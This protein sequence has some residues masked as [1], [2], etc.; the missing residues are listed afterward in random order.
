MNSLQVGK[1][2]E[3]FRLETSKMWKLQWGRR[4]LSGGSYLGKL[5]VVVAKLFGGQVWR[6]RARTGSLAWIPG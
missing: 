1:S 4:G 3:G 2:G 5:E 6:V